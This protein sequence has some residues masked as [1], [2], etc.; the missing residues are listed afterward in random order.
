MEPDP[1][2]EHLVKLGK[3]EMHELQKRQ[4]A[5]IVEQLNATHGLPAI[6]Q[7]EDTPARTAMREADTVKKL[8]D[9]LDRFEANQERMHREIMAILKPPPPSPREVPKDRAKVRSA[10]TA[11]NMA[12]RMANK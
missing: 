4:K 10:E 1:I 12:T 11:K 7:P 6:N 8:A 3:F 9:A 2:Q 5:R